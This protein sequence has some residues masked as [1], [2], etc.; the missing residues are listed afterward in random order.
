MNARSLILIF[1]ICLLTC[2]LVSAQDKQTSNSSQT[3]SD[4]DIGPRKARNPLAD[5]TSFAL[6]H[7]F[8]FKSGPLERTGYEL[9]AS[10]VAPTRITDEWLFLHR[11]TLRLVRDPESFPGQGTRFGLGDFTYE[12]LFTRNRNSRMIW[13]AGPAFV[14]PTATSSRLGSGKWS[15]GPAA[16]MVSQPGHWTFG[17]LAF[18]TWSIAGSSDRNQVNQLTLEPFVSYDL[19][20]DWFV[21]SRPQISADWKAPR[22]ERWTMPFGGGGGKGFARGEKNI[23]VSV[24]AY[25]NVERPPGSSPWQF[26]FGLEFLFNK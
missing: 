16:G 13:G 7:A 3:A 6:D 5:K 19:K 26:S 17:A 4:Q 25:Y 11:A 14:I 18:N 9:D 15:L 8:S 10:I 21:S 23:F 22:G 2:A 1:S 24:F 12:A 20:G